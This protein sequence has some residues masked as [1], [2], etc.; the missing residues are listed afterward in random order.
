MEEIVEKIIIGVVGA[1]IGSGVTVPIVVHFKNKKVVLKQK[2]GK[3][4]SLIQA[5]RDVNGK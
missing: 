3:E 2:A 1:F 4:S 5:G